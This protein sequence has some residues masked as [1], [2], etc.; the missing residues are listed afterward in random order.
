MSLRKSIQLPSAVE[1]SFWSVGACLYNRRE[2]VIEI[3]ALGYLD[4]D[5]YAA[6][7][8]PVTQKI[9]RVQGDEAEMPM[10]ALHDAAGGILYAALKETPEFADAANV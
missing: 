10:H 3:V 6:G 9:V 1:V 8:E 2:N 5:A 4:V 7:A